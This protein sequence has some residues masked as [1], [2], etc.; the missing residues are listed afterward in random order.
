MN[1]FWCV[2]DRHRLRVCMNELR[3]Y[4]YS[5]RSAFILAA[6]ATGEGEAIWLW[7]R[8]G[9]SVNHLQERTEAVAA[10]CWARDARVRRSPK[11][12]ALV[13]V[14]ILRRDPLART[15]IESVG[16][17]HTRATP[18]EPSNAPKASIKTTNPA[19]SSAASSAASVSPVVS[20]TGE[21]VSDYV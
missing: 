2:T 16:A 9:L 20:R 10:A 17:V 5:G 11:L 4:N 6:R 1:R 18:P 21:D 19:T 13:R 15:H 3:T 8:P 14:D 7:L 12:A